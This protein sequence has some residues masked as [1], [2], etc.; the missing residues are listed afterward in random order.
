MKH[1]LLRCPSLSPR[2]S[3][4]LVPLGRYIPS[5]TFKE[6]VDL[7]DPILSRFDLICV[8]RDIVGINKRP[9]SISLSLSLS[10]PVSVSLSLGLCYVSISFCLFL[11]LSLRLGLSLL[12]VIFLSLC[13]SVSVCVSVQPDADEDLSL[14]DYVVSSHQL[15]HPGIL[16]L[17]RESNKRIA[18]LEERMIQAQPHEPINQQLLQKYIL[19]ARYLDRVFSSSSLFL[20]LSL[21]LYIYIRLE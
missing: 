3:S 9:T 11:S 6:N 7:S 20:C 18:E 21:S 12:S 2:L 4:S 8:L 19:Y 15:H 5:Y 1:L 10:L 14:A 13:L 16:H 17:H